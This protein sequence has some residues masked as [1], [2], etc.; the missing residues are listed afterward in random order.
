MKTTRIKPLIVAL[1]TLSVAATSQA[2]VIADIAGDYV[3]ATAEPAG[4]DYLSSS[5][6][7]GGTEAVLTPGTVVG[8]GGNSGFEGTSLN[9]TPAV[10]GAIDGGAEFEIFSDGYAAHGAV[11]GTDL[12]LHPGNSAATSFTIVRYTVDAA[13]ITN[14]TIGSISGS[15]RDLAGGTTGVS[16]G[17]ITA[18]IYQNTTEI[19]GATGSAGRLTQVDGTFNIT[20]LTVAE[21]D[22]FSFVVGRNGHY[23]G[24][25]TALTGTIDLATAAVPEP[26]SAAL[27][28]LGALSLLLRRRR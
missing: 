9:N 7:T 28:G 20:G 8:N 5:A 16:A 2:A 6:A 12:L 19:F 26:S 17:S 27:A 10:L 18:N 11:E 23:G 21:G 22:T 13:D 25:E 3:D 4:W 24:D 15:F 1:T 14:G